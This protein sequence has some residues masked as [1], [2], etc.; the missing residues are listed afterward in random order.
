[1]SKISLNLQRGIETFNRMTEDGKVPFS[2]RY[3]G[4]KYSGFDGLSLTKEYCDTEIGRK[5]KLSASPDKNLKVSTEVL[6]NGE[7][8]EVEYTVYFENT[9]K[10]NSGELSDI[11]MFDGTFEGDGPMIRSCMGDH[12][13]KYAAYDHDLTKA[14]KYYLSEEGR[15]THKV[16]PYFD[17][18]HGDGGTLLA[19]GWAGTWEAAFSYVGGVTRLLAKTNVGFDAVLLPGEKIR[20]GLMVMLPYSGRNSD[21]A[22]NLWREWFMKYNLPKADTA[23]KSLEP[24][25]TTFWAYDTGLPNSDGSISERYFTWRPT[26]D[27]IIAEGLKFDFRWFDAGW[28][29]DPAGNTVETDWWGTTGS[30]ELDRDKWPGKTFRE[31]NE[32]CHEN[33]IRVLCWFEP[34]RV[35]HV[36]DLVKNYGYDP[37]WAIPNGTVVTSNIGDEKC[38]EWTLGRITKMMGEN[39]VD[40]YRE[41]N[42]SDPGFSWRTLDRREE[43][44]YGVKRHGIAENKCICG[45]Y[46]LWDGIIDFCAKNGKCTFVDSCASGGG[47]NDIESMRRG[48]PL[49]RSDA[50]RTTTSLRLSMTTSFCKWIPFH[51]SVVK[52]TSYELAPST[53]KG[54]DSYVSRASFLPIFNFSEAFVHNTE[55]DFDLFRKNLSEWRSI[56]RLLTKDLYVL[57][58]WHHDSNRSDWT[59]LAYNDEETGDGVL[60]AF[61]MEEANSP[62]FTAKLPFAEAGAKYVLENADTGEKSVLDG[63]ELQSGILLTADEPRTSI[64]IRIKKL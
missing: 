50:D 47:R 8:G 56:S 44:K 6:L 20:T 40:M 26:L 24:F 5:V 36:D 35:T 39:E 42:N 31:S 14:D 30:W 41:D 25:A 4:K 54:V 43:E 37:E 38:L 22:T 17:L 11:Y 61:R 52:E 15:A 29:Y 10:A 16:F 9:G 45:H 58:P 32:A 12:V 34:E 33:G 48:F 28:Y 51:G 21:N 7:F 53:G 3:N 62:T 64:M 49:M 2:F 57:T 18:V 63:V 59:V 23:G 60:L 27:K 55:L 19:L 1:M 13:N 46:K